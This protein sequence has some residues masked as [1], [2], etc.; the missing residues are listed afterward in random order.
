MRVPG[1]AP[2]VELTAKTKI[3]AGVAEAEKETATASAE[4]TTPQ[5]SK[6]AA[7][8]QAK[9]DKNNAMKTSD[10]DE[11]VIAGKMSSLSMQP[12]LGEETANSAAVTQQVPLR[13]ANGYGFVPNSAYREAGNGKERRRRRRAMARRRSSWRSSSS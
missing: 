8:R 5:I 7:K 1:V 11:K 9:R 12:S 13:P 3:A 4:S 6:K 2:N 10:E